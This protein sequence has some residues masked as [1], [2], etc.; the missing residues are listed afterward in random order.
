MRPLLSRALTGMLA[1]D[2]T[3]LTRTLEAAEQRAGEIAGEKLTA[4]LGQ[5]WALVKSPSSRPTGPRRF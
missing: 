5:G 3:A 2:V 1:A 4:L